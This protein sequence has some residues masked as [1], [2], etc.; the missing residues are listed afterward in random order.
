M[1]LPPETSVKQNERG[2]RKV[3]SDAMSAAASL[4]N[5][6]RDNE[7]IRKFG[8]Y[9]GNEADPLVYIIR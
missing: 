6:F 7:L 8:S 5:S 3:P 4:S 1:C 9:K 2:G